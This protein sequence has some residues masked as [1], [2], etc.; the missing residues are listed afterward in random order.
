MSYQ[1]GPVGYMENE[2]RGIYIKRRRGVG[3]IRDCQ[4]VYS[5]SRFQRLD[6]LRGEV[7]RKRRDQRRFGKF[8][9]NAI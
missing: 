3:K 8:F 2:K 5:A 9:S 1:P 4:A 7:L 6:R